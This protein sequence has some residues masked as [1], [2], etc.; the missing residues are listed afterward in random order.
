MIGDEVRHFVS[1]IRVASTLDDS[2]YIRFR[3]KKIYTLL[4]PSCI[5]CMKLDSEEVCMELPV[6]FAICFTSGLQMT[7]IFRSQITS[8]GCLAIIFSFLIRW[9]HVYMSTTLLLLIRPS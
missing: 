3:Q 6:C 8:Q 2:E 4:L 9:L 7:R 1:T 5:R